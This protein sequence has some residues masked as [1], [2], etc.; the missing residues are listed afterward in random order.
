[1][2][3]TQLKKLSLKKLFSWKS[4]YLITKDH[5]IH[6]WMV[7]LIVIKTSLV[8][9]LSS[10]TASLGRGL[11]RGELELGITQSIIAGDAYLYS[12]LI[13][14]PL[15]GRICGKVGAKTIYFIGTIFF[16]VGMIG[17]GYSS[18]FQSYFIFKLV[19]GIGKAAIYVLSL[20]ILN[21]HLPE[22]LKN[23]G[24]NIY[25]TL[26]FGF[27][28]GIGYL[29]SGYIIDYVGWRFSFIYPLY[30]A[31]I[32]LIFIWITFYDEKNKNPLKLDYGG[33]VSFL[34]FFL[35]LLTWISTAKTPRNTEGFHSTYALSILGV[36]IISCIY[37]I[38]H[39]FFSKSP[40]FSLKIFKTPSF[41]LGVACLFAVKLT[42]S[43]TASDFAGIMLNNLKYRKSTVGLLVSYFGFALA[44]S[45]LMSHFLEKKMGIVRLI[46]LAIILNIISCFSSHSITIQSEHYEYI[47]IM[48]LR[49]VSLG[50]SL[51]PLVSLCIRDFNHQDHHAYPAASIVSLVSFI[52]SSFGTKLL[53]LIKALRVPFH[54]LR[55]GEQVNKQSPAYAEYL[56]KRTDFLIENTGATASFT[57]N[58]TSTVQAYGH[59]DN[60]SD[61]YTLLRSGA[62]SIDATKIAFGQLKENIEAQAQILSIFD[63]YWIFGWVLFALL[64]GLILFYWREGNKCVPNK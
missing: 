48:V 44:A 64:L 6:P 34:L 18:G 16:Y 12:M 36:T 22:R 53:G 52:G 45:G 54:T 2:S 20:Q 35:G 61:S 49:G 38:T 15:I 8:G 55:F 19:E 23:L 37:F 50:F 56:D 40:L 57:G 25:T 13:F 29:L 7:L 1:M 60:T 39:S 4:P 42:Y 32:T 28:M 21:S 24:V 17:I 33:L 27:G 5:P 47:L 31:P 30:T 14:I 3:T 26:F 62:D 43:S 11:I 41:S 46:I 10:Y 59:V 51:G 9:N 63:G 58:L